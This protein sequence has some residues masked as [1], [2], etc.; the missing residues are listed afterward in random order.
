MTKC[1]NDS[2]PV[3]FNTSMVTDDVSFSLKVVLML[4]SLSSCTTMFSFAM[5]Q[6]PLVFTFVPPN[7]NGVIW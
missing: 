5:K 6:G 1:L 7:I 4:T 3:L 2:R